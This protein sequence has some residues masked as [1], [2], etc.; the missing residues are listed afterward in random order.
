MATKW[1]LD[2]A[3]SELGFKVRHLMITNVSGQI[4]TFSATAESE[5]DQFSSARV[6]F[7]ADLT[8]LHTGDTNR[9]NHLKSADFF[10]TEKYPQMTFESTSF[11]GSKLEGHL[12]IKGIT[13]PVVLDVEFG[14]VGKDPWGNIKAGFTL[15]GKINRKDWGLNWNAPLEAGGVLVSEEVKIHADIQLVKA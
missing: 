13:H 8:S 11:N 7:S 5:D 6:S 12:A 1:N 14:G 10:E 4:G 9:D 15:Q 3:H 2:P